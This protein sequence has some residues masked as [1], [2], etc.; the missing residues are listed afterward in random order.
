MRNELPLQPKKKERGI[1]NM[2][3]AKGDGTHWVAFKKINNTVWYF[4][5]YGNLK[6]P[7]EVIK[8]FKN[9]R[10]LYNHKNYQK[11][12]AYNC[13]HHCLKFLLDKYDEN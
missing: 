9:C 10:I 11:N 2:D 12:N 1:I 5:S 8:Y 3:D 4:D 7:R 6:P 13:G